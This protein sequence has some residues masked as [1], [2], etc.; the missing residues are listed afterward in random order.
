MNEIALKGLLKVAK[1][2]LPPD[3]IREAVNALIHSAIDYKK[4]VILD[5]EAGEKQVTAQFYEID[6]QVYFAIAIFNENNQ[7]VR[8]ENIQPVTTLV[9]ILLKKL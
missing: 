3:A 7:V 6:N 1:N 9:E 4:Q 5:T 8:F 2:L